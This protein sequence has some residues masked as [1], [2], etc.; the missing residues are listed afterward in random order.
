MKA[1]VRIVG[2]ATRFTKENPRP[3]PGRPKTKIIREYARKI[4]QEEDPK[5]KKLIAQECVEILIKY[6]R[7]GSLGHLQQFLQLIES[8]IPGAGWTGDGKLDS[9]S[10][11]KLVAK[12]CR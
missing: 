12:L 6:A 10:L 2:Q 11:A 9:D 5:T 7:K 1:D 8:D 3:G 4:V